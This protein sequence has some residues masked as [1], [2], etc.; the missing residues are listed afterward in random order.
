VLEEEEAMEPRQA[1]PVAVCPENVSEVIDQAMIGWSPVLDASVWELMLGEPPA[2]AEVCDLPDREVLTP[3]P[4]SF[5]LR[6]T[7]T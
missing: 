3:I 4:W 1:L 2:R 7:S 6:S 5:G